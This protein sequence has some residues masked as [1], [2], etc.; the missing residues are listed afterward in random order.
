MA[1]LKYVVFTVKGDKKEKLTI[2]RPEKFGG[3]ITYSSYADL[4]KDFIDKKL[5]PLDVKNALTQEL[6]TLLA[7]IRKHHKELL[8]LHEKAY[9]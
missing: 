5:H 8:A 6:N 9:S 3:N 2:S 4:E 1:F 7:P